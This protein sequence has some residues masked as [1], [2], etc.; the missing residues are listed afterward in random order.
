MYDGRLRPAP[1]NQ[2][3]RLILGKTADPALKSTGIQFVSV[4]HKGCSQRSEEEGEVIRRLYACL[5]SQHFV[6]C[7][8]VQ[9]PLSH[10]NV[11]VITPYN[12]QVNYLRSIL[13]ADARVGT[14]DKLQGQQE[15]QVVRFLW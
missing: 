10:E 3:Q 6:D 1:D 12:M 5:L 2:K 4:D 8:G 7:E 9:H 15:A 11:M 13:P 14:V